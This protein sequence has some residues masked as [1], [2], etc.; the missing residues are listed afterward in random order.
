MGATRHVPVRM[1]V[2][3]RRRLPQAELARHVLAPEGGLVADPEKTRPGRGWYLCPDRACAARFARF[4]PAGRRVARGR[5]G[6]R[7]GSIAQGG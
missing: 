1:C 6:G 5:R 2:I 3:C 4:R 7:A